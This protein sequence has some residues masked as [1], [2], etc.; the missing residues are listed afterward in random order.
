M[1]LH[2]LVIN[3]LVLF[4]WL[5]CTWLQMWVYLHLC[6]LHRH[7]TEPY[8]QLTDNYWMHMYFSVTK[9]RLQRTWADIISS[10]LRPSDPKE[11]L[12]NTL[13]PLTLQWPYQHCQNLLN[14]SFRFLF[15]LRFVFH[16]LLCS[17]VQSF[18]KNCWFVFWFDPSFPLLFF[19]HLFHH[20]G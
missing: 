10:I 11:L 2:V 17:Y 3:I 18:K 19:Y 9:K 16:L 13:P 20:S 6:T 5:D 4:L 7:K 8:L 15:S 12:S 14:L 1:L